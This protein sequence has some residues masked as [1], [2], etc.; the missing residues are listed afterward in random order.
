MY[1][2]PQEEYTGLCTVVH[3]VLGTLHVAHSHNAHPLADLASSQEEEE[4]GTR[5]RLGYTG[6]RREDVQVSPT[7]DYVRIL[8][9]CTYPVS[10]SPP[11]RL[12]HC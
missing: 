10:L 6:D 2:L 5:G 1:A 4:R 9:G 11:L 8:V 12:E 7:K 3:R